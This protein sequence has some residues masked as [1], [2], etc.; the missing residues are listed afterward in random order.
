MNYHPGHALSR[1]KP[2]NLSQL[3][4]VEYIGPSGGEAYESGGGDDAWKKGAI[5]KTLVV[6]CLFAQGCSLSDTMS[7]GE[8]RDSICIP[9]LQMPC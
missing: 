3:E 9:G 7:T 6:I 8:I 2:Q 4:F 5:I 1:N